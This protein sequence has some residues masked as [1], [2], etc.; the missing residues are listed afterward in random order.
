MT[1]LDQSRYQLLGTL[2]GDYGNSKITDETFWKEME[3]HRFTQDD[4]DAWCA[5]FYA[6]GPVAHGRSQ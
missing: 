3:R 6:N 4:I 2:L 5:A 1:T